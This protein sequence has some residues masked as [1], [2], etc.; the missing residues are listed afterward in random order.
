MQNVNNLSIFSYDNESMIPTTAALSSMAIPIGYF[1]KN[2]QKLIIFAQG[3]K[4]EFITNDK[5]QTDIA[6]KQKETSQD[7][8][9]IKDLQDKIISIDKR[10]T[11][12]E[13]DIVTPLKQAFKLEQK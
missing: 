9:T 4:H 11:C 13:T 5:Y 12:I 7:I 3:Q 2:Q 10:I 8:D 1:V 6:N